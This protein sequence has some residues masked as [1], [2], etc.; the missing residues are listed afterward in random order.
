MK[1]LVTLVADL[2]M[3]QTLR[4]LLSRPQ[5]LGIKPIEYEILRHPQHDPG[6]W[7]DADNLLQSQSKNFRYALVLFDHEGS[8]QE[9]REI[10]DL[11]DELQ[12]RLI[13]K[14]WDED[15][16]RVVIIKPELEIWVWSESPQVDACMG[17]AGKQPDLRSWLRTHNL[18]GTDE[19]K[20]QN[21]KEAVELAL[22]AV[23]KPRSAAIYKQLAEKVSVQRCTDSSFL[24]LKETLQEWFK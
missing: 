17:W 8:G 22:R 3:E 4:G 6:C 21:P 14:G 12:A 19:I 23:K 10:E 20:P 16:A 2:D 15:R 7:N 1:D 13:G 18:L 9:K 24:R 11:Q 5:S